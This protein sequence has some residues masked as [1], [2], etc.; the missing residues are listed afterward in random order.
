[1]A[2]DVI[3]GKY[4]KI[5]DT[6][7]MSEAQKGNTN[8]FQK[9]NIP[10]NKGKKHSVETRLKIG[11]ANRK[12]KGKKLSVGHREKI[13]IAMQ[14]FKGENNPSKRLEVREKQRKAK[15]GKPRLNMRGANHPKWKGGARKIRKMIMGRIEYIRWREM[16]LARDNWTCQNCGKRSGKEF[17]YLVSHHIKSWIEYPELRYDINNGIILCRECHL[18]IHKK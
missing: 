2:L 8:G 11:L 10:W 13:K 16:I 14:K 6:S 4:W 18:L 17:V 15:L 3:K 1:M 7:K 12:R 9:G 5:R